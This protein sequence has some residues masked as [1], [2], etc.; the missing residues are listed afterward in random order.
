MGARRIE[1]AGRVGYPGPGGHGS[2]HRDGR[3]R[4]ER[5][6]PRFGGAKYGDDGRDEARTKSGNVYVGDGKRNKRSVW[7]INT[8]A[9]SDAHFAT[10]P[11]ALVEPCILAGSRRG[12]TVLDPFAGAGTVGV[13]AAGHDRRFVGIELNPE[14]ADMARRRIADRIGP[15]FATQE[16]IA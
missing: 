11:E 15:L 4:G 3:E 5:V 16:E 10:F 7:T 8:Q 2:F 13:V 1:D 6:G 12:D 9:F 14:Y